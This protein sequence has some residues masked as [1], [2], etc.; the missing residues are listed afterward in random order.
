MPVFVKGSIENGTSGILV[1]NGIDDPGQ[2]E[3]TFK[4]SSGASGP[5][6]TI[7]AKTVTELQ[8]HL[9]KE[10]LT[11]EANAMNT[12]VEHVEGHAVA[13]MALSGVTDATLYINHPTGPCTECRLALEHML[14]QGSKL[15]IYYI[16]K[17]KTQPVEVLGTAK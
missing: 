5:A 16:E 15:M 12:A 11:R 17:G 1:V 10:E 6:K 4:L 14:P 8:K 13:L 2:L 7:Y 9:T 3:V